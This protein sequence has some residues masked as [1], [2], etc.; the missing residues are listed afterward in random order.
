MNKLRYQ[1]LI[2]L[3]LSITCISS[4][5]AQEP[6][7]EA[8]RMLTPIEAIQLADQNPA[9][10]FT[11]TFEITVRSSKMSRMRV[12]LNSEEDYRDKRCLTLVLTRGNAVKI[13]KHLGLSLRKDLINKKIRVHG[14]A[15]RKKIVFK[16]AG[17][18]TGRF[19]YQ[20]HIYV[21]DPDQIQLVDEI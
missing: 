18:V 12:Y 10:G 14:T 5:R 2:L 20:T 11:G 13:G 19:Y 8:G 16:S 21:D 7:A 9:G 6:A 1:S 4:S 3:I 17:R 15:K